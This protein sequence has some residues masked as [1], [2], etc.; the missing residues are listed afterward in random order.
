MP[1]SPDDS[2]PC[3][4]RDR[5]SPTNKCGGLRSTECRGPETAKQLWDAETQKAVGKTDTQSTPATK[6]FFTD[7]G[8]GL[9]PCDDNAKEMDVVETK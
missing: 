9:I 6:W 8:K 1:R 4:E 3:H 2:R 5:G 7:S